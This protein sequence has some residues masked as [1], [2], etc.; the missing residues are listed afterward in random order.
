M[1]VAIF[2][3]AIYTSKK[4]DTFFDLQVL[5]KNLLLLCK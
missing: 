5:L 1:N 4:I 3:F 2:Q